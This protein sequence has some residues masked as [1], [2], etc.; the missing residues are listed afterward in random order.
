[1]DFCLWD[2]PSRTHGPT[3]GGQRGP[4]KEGIS[5]EFHSPLRGSGP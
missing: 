1:M 5:A 4:S 2:Q 3:E